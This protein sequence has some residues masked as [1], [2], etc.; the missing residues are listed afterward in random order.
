MKVTPRLASKVGRWGYR[1]ARSLEES[2]PG[3]LEAMGEEAA[4]EY[5]ARINQE[6]KDRFSTLV[7]MKRAEKHLR[8]TARFLE[9]EQRLRTAT[10]EAESEVMRELIL[11]QS[12][13]DEAASR[14]GYVGWPGEDETTG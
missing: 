12:P 1:H 14:T 8:P 7:V 13:E 3:T 5:L 11:V 4:L 10:M 9:N 6:A 2:R